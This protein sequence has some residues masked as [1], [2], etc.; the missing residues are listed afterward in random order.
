MIHAHEIEEWEGPGKA[1]AWV[2]HAHPPA[3]G[4]NHGRVK[5]GWPSLGPAENVIDLLVKDPDTRYL[6]TTQVEEAGGG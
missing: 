1:P 2:L 5:I 4:H 6:G 3:P